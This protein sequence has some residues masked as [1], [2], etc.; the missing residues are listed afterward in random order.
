MLRQIV[1]EFRGSTVKYCSWFYIDLALLLH[2][3][4]LAMYNY[5]QQSIVLCVAQEDVSRRRVDAKCI[6]NRTAST[7]HLK[8]AYMERKFHCFFTTDRTTTRE[9]G[10]V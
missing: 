4:H 1:F 6:G 8:H 9:C 3:Q 5:Y 7:S 2:N 10:H